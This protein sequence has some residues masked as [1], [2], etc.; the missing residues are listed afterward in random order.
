MKLMTKELMKMIPNL[1]ATSEESDP[2][3]YVKLFNPVGIG[4]WYICEYDPEDET[5]FGQAELHFKEL[6]YFSLKEIKELRLPLGMKVER[7]LYFEPK[8]LSELD[9]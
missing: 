6:G 4:T 8:R 5:C 9:D 7:D 1:G 3:A 2:M